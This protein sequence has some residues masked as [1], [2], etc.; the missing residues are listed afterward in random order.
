VVIALKD[1]RAALETRPDLKPY[2]RD[3]YGM[4][5]QWCLHTILEYATAID[6]TRPVAVIHEEN[7]YFVSAMAVFKWMKTR[8]PIGRNLQTFSF[9]DKKSYTPLQAA[10]ALAFEGARRI[11][12]QS[13]PERR[14]LSALAP[15]TYPSRLRYVDKDGMDTFI[16][17]LEAMKILHASGHYTP[18]SWG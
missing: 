3:E 1:V 18:E 7:D 5:F 14:A 15:E 11:N 13:G 8:H 9:G 2:F 4:C 17:M 12:F 6:P 16:G 10:D